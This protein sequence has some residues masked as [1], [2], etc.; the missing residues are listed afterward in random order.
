L[1]V[2]WLK[3]GTCVVM[4]R[5][6]LASALVLLTGCGSDGEPRV[7]SDREQVEAA[8]TGYL[9]ALA[10][11]DGEEACRHVAERAQRDL[12]T[13]ADARSCADPIEKLH[14]ALDEEQ[15]DKLRDSRAARIRIDGARAEVTI[16]GGDTIPF[17]KV[18]GGGWKAVAFGSGGGYRTRAEGECIIGG[19]NEFDDGG[20]HAFWR[21]EGRADF[22]DFIVETCRRADRQG[23]LVED[24]GEAEQRKISR[25]AGRVIAVM[26]ERGQIRDPR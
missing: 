5:W 8:M 20:G 26:V 21:R 13:I 24:G 15:R 14:E 17:E 6:W 23:L 16:A 9:E 3:P 22:R 11:G 12:A 4:A 7:G 18:D 10:D 2:V 19:M 1:H 25:I